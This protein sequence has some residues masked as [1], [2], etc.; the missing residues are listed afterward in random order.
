MNQEVAIGLSLKYLL[1]WQTDN[2]DHFYCVIY[3]DNNHNTNLYYITTRLIFLILFAVTSFGFIFMNILNKRR[4]SKGKQW[5][6]LA[7]AYMLAHEDKS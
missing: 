7:I 3:A 4:K 5:E 2:S 1:T 6:S